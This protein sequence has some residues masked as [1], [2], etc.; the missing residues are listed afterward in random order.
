M[1]CSI[2]VSPLY[3]NL[4]VTNFQ[5]CECAPVC[6][7]SH[8]CCY[9]VAQLCPTLLQPC[10]LQP[11]RL[12]CPWDFP[13]K[14]TGVGCHFLLH[15]IFPDPGIEL[16]SPALAGRFFTTEPPGKPYCTPLL[17][18][19][20]YCTVRLSVFIFVFVFVYYLCEKYYKPIALQYYIADCVNSVPRLTQLDLQTDWTYR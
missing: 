14:N 20:R 3:M 10:G 11:V 7:L 17:Y 5:R 15:R 1:L 16:T 6:Q 12:F 18:F 13:G 4:Q 2:T 19:S 9:L 8:H